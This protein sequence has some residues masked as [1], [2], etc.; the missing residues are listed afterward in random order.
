MQLLAET[1]IDILYCLMNV[2]LGIHVDI[3]KNST[4]FKKIY[5][6]FLIL[7]LM[8]PLSSRKCSDTWL[9]KTLF[10]FVT[11]HIKMLEI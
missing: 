5:L 3:S 1:H 8:Y 10:C 4:S 6:I 7:N 2:V 9:V 11:I